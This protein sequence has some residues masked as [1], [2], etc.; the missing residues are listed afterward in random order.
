MQRWVAQQAPEC[1]PRVGAAQPRPWT[2]PRVYDPP[3]Y[4]PPVYDP[5]VYDP[6]VYDPPVYD[7]PVYDP[8][9][10]DPPVYDPPVY[11]PPVYD[12]CEVP[13]PARGAPGPSGLG[14]AHGRHENGG[15]FGHTASDGAQTPR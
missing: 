10:Y 15:P 1:G 3:V 6:P 9:V 14:S 4:D 12:P 7:P 8:P 11:D 2:T 13:A 5:P